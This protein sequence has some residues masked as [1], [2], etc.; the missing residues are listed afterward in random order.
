MNSRTIQS[1]SSW[2]ERSSRGQGHSKWVYL[3]CSLFVAASLWTPFA[4]WAADIVDVRVGQHEQ[5]TRVVFEL[6]AFVGYQIEQHGTDLMIA[7]D[8]GAQPAEFTPS[9]GLVHSVE[10]ARSGQNSVA[11]LKLDQGGLRIKE[12]T[13]ASPSSPSHSAT[14]FLAK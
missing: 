3:S 6:N 10:I 2:C 4:A 5:Y 13:L 8:A 1:R 7:F 11:L 14:T 9:K 12:M